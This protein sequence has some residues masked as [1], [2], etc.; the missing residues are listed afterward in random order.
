MSE[1]TPCD[2]RIE[3]EAEYLEDR[4]A[5]EEGYFSFSYRIVI[6]NQGRQTV[7][8]LSRKWVITDGEGRQETVEGPGVVGHQP[9]LAPGETFEYTSY[10]PLPTPVGTMHGV[11]HMV[12]AD[13]G[14]FD[15]E[16]SP[17]TLAVP[18]TLN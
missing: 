10:C 13:G 17:F 14:R 4:S 12:V 3:A 7:Q 5:P 9:I 1:T 16:I 6:S 2:I 18:G 8:L 11:Y 15:A